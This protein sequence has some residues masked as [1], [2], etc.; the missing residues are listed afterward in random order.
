MFVTKDLKWPLSLLLTLPTTDH[1]DGSGQSITDQRSRKWKEIAILQREKSKKMLSWVTQHQSGK[2]KAVIC[3]GIECLSLKKV[4]PKDW[5]EEMAQ[6][7]Q[8][9]GRREKK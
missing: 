3:L 2:R 1:F 8:Q 9:K 4:L 7:N 5:E 6:A